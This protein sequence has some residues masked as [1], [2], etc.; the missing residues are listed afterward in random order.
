MTIRAVVGFRLAELYNVSNLYE[1]ELHAFNGVPVAGFAV[2]QGGGVAA[3]DI[4]YAG[5]IVNTGGNIGA[6]PHAIFF[7]TRQ[8]V[9]IDGQGASAGFVN[10]RS[11]IQ[12]CGRDG[13]R[14]GQGHHNGQSSGK[15]F[16]DCF[17]NIVLSFV[18]KLYGYIEMPEDGPLA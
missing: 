6:V 9:F 11:V 17:H 14:Q 12:R 8:I 10:G 5:F 15:D 1:A 16:F 2:A 3:Q 18:K 4:I 7:G 13:E